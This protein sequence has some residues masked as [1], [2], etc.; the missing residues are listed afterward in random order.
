MQETWV[1]SLGKED[2]LE[3]GMATHSSILAW[4]ILCTEK[5]GRLLQSMGVTKRD[6]TK[7]LILSLS[8]FHVKTDLKNAA[9]DQ[10][11]IV[12][13]LFCKDKNH[14]SHHSRANNIQSTE[15][16]EKRI[17]SIPPFHSI[18]SSS[19]TLILHFLPL[20]AP[21]GLFLLPFFVLVMVPVVHIGRFYFFP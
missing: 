2:S 16:L 8:H 14:H 15:A 17:N 11:G 6:T 3:K 12:N 4:R 7:W 18:S 19:L 9:N 21:E 20:L 13:T 10:R 1:P 5:A